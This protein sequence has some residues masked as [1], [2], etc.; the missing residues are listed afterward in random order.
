MQISQCLCLLQ[1]SLDSARFKLQCTQSTWSTAIY[2]KAHIIIFINLYS[3]ITV[4]NCIRVETKLIICLW[5]SHTLDDGAKWNE[6]T[7]LPRPCWCRGWHH[8]ACTWE[9]VRTPLQQ[10][11]TDHPW[12]TYCHFSCAHVPLPHS[13]SSSPLFLLHLLLNSSGC[14]LKEIK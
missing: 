11:H 5:Q 1:V 9:P 12:R 2:K 10:C 14:E 6:Q 8:M 13:L 7:S 3:C 4:W